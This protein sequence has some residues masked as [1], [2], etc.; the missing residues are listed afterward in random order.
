MH[1]EQR[2][3]VGLHRAV[4]AALRR[5]LILAATQQGVSDEGFAVPVVGPLLRRL[6]LQAS[7]SVGD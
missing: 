6:D 7:R 5:E 1:V 4:A 2:A 3:D